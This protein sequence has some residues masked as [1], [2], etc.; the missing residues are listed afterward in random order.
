[1]TPNE[2]AFKVVSFVLN[3]QKTTAKKTDNDSVIT[4]R[5]M[6]FLSGLDSVDRMLEEKNLNEMLEAKWKKQNQYNLINQK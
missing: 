1:M 6:L 2:T 4:D 5:S 3:K